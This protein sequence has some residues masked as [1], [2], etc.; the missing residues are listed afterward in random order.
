MIA[1]GF[2]LSFFEM[3][4]YNYLIKKFEL[5]FFGYFDQYCEYDC[6]LEENMDE[7]IE[8]A[9]VAELFFDCCLI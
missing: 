8:Q 5:L 4:Y 6:L 2:V 1:V 7:K 3:E 9:L